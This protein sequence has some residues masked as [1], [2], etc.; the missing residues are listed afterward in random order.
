MKTSDLMVRQGNWLFRYRSYLPI[1]LVLYALICTWSQRSRYTVENIWLDIS[2]IVV[3]LGGQAIRIMAVGYAADRTSGRNTKAQVANEINQT[4]IYSLI[5]H[6]LYVGNFFMWL[7]IALFTR[8]WWLTLIFIAIYCLYYERII[9][10]EEEYL[11]GKFGESYSD[12][13][14]QV[15]SVIPGWK[16]YQPNKYHFRIKK[17]L[18]Q[19]NSSLYGLMLVFVVLEVAQDFFRWQELRLEKHWII[20]GIFFTLLYLTLRFLKKKTNILRNDPIRQKIYQ[21]E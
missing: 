15:N 21:A 11:V 12:Y 9:M 8:I 20:G 5:R 4:G 19:E 18:R 13:S 7:G 1:A 17:V 2:C 16:S 6:P 10:A 3:A 14:E